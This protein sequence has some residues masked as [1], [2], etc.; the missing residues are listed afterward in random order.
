ME[1][2]VKVEL[3]V[4]KDHSGFWRDVTV[5]LKEQEIESIALRVSCLQ[6]PNIH[7]DL[8]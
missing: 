5:F 3:L 4:G 1:A 8:L 7:T 6:C 2:V